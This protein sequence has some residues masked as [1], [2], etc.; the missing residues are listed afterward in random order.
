MAGARA[1]GGRMYVLIMVGVVDMACG[2]YVRTYVL[3]SI[4][5]AVV[6]RTNER[7]SLPYM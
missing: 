1:W 3:V 6:G 4:S 5:T 2:V 7:N